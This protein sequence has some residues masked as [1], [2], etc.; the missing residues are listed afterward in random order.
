MDLRSLQLE[1][2]HLELKRRTAD[3]LV[4]KFRALKERLKAEAE[5]RETLQAKVQCNWR[6]L[7][8]RVQRHVP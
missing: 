5:A 2:E 6:R 7:T 1:A 8:Q 3:D 4:P